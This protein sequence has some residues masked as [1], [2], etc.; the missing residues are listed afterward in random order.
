MNN[1]LVKKLVVAVVLSYILVF[2]IMPKDK[3]LT[4]V[5]RLG[6]VMP[7]GHL[8]ALGAD[9][10]EVS[11]D[12]YTNLMFASRH[13]VTEVVK[14]L[15]ENGLD[16]NATTKSG[17]TA[18][19]S[20]ASA[21]SYYTTRYLKENG[22][23][24]NAA[25]N[26]GRTPLLLAISKEEWRLSDY[27]MDVGADVNKTTDYV[28][29]SLK[30]ALD[31]DKFKINKNNGWTALMEASS[32][33]NVDIMEN[34]LFHGANINKRHHDGTNAL[35]WAV[36]SGNIDAV[37][38]LLDK[39]IETGNSTILKQDILS[40]AK[41][42]K[43]FESRLREKE[44]GFET[45]EN[46]DAILAYLKE[47]VGNSNNKSDNRSLILTVTTK[48]VDNSPKPKSNTGYSFAE[49]GA[50]MSG[51]YWRHN[52]DKNV[53]EFIKINAGGSYERLT[54]A[55]KFNLTMG[56]GEDSL[57]KL[58]ETKTKTGKF[59]YMFD[60]PSATNYLTYL[61]NLGRNLEFFSGNEEDLYSD[62]TTVRVTDGPGGRKY[63]RL[64]RLSFKGINDVLEFDRSDIA[65]FTNRVL[66]EG[67]CSKLHDSDHSYYIAVDSID[68]KPNLFP[69]IY[70]N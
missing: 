53:E 57:G 61:K 10:H 58:I 27:L 43:T 22:A 9:I 31:T 7:V 41:N 28:N 63:Y 56:G 66:Y 2:W 30:I 8:V 5:M 35:F 69:D 54:Y 24:I 26:Y 25:S 16:V 3:A 39:G 15:V 49:I 51:L 46:T 12:G 14:Y 32:T 13:G 17:W 62:C 48:K 4:L 36:K 20:A 70:K 18:L 23:D 68:I 29:H 60:Q 47:Y 37:K 45:K 44:T 19:M 52:H 11:E 59:Y 6:A 67:S 33:G 64:T 1:S 65:R 42:V 40:F 50:T 55:R 21:G 34:T 38:F